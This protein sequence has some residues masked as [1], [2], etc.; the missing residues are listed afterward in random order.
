MNNK[1][2]LRRLEIVFLVRYF[3]IGGLERVVIALAN[4]YVKRGHAVRIIVISKGKRNSLI[5]E[6]D[7]R[8]EIYF[9][10]GTILKKIKLLRQLTKNRLIHI[11]F[12]DGKIH[13]IIR[14]A[15]I[16]RKKVITYHSVYRHKRNRLLNAIDFMFSCSIKRVVAVSD[17]VKNFCIEDIHLAPQKITVIKNGINV[18]DRSINNNI[19][20][21]RNSFNILVLCSLY[22]H[23]NHS[24]LI[25]MIK[26][27]SEHFNDSFKLLLIGDGPCLSDVFLEAK[28][29]EINQNIEWFGAVWN[30]KLVDY[31]FQNADVFVSASKYE[32]FPISILEAM[33]YRL[34]LL[35]SD[36]P[37]HREIGENSAIFYSLDDYPDF[38]NKLFYL[39]QN[40]KI[41]EELGD[42]SFNQLKQYDLRNTADQYIA[43]YNEVL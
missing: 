32:G 9:L 35:L 7:K 41:R 5:T 43:V 27:Y 34:P 17:A 24:Q 33:R 11:N 28:E 4:E 13:P 37:P 21:K 19:V 38:S 26:Y 16:G 20:E 10:D 23:K 12:G 40:R 42:A 31:I 6:L 8:V 3:T 29:L 15:I 25:K 36:I 30:T 1:T 22:P 2:D 39:F 18:E 14:L